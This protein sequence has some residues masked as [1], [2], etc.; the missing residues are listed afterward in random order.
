MSCDIISD[1]ISILV[2]KTVVM[3]LK[4]GDL[5]VISQKNSHRKILGLVM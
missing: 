4:N 3:Y 5:N 1:V 2:K